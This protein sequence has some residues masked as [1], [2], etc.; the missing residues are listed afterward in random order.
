[1]LAVIDFDT[2]AQ[3]MSVERSLHAHFADRQ[4]RGE[5]FKFDFA[6]HKDKEA[7]NLGCKKVLFIDRGLSS[8]WVKM[9]GKALTEMASYKKAMFLSNKKRSELNAS[10][11][12]HRKLLYERKYAARALS[13]KW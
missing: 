4:V 9:S 13:A 2:R 1:M 11:R 7:F 12:L 5:W 10:N 6:Q 8:W 3:A